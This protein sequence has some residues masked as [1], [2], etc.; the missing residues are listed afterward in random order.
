MLEPFACGEGGETS[1]ITASS[2]AECVTHGRVSSIPPSIRR[3]MRVN[4]CASA[5]RL[6]RNVISRRCIKGC[7]NDSGSCVIP[8]HTSRPANPT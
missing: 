7:V 5:L 4:S 2:G 1:L 6:A 3:M 8:T